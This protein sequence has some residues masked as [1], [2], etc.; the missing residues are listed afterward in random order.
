LAVQ[1]N[2]FHFPLLVHPFRDVFLDVQNK[3]VTVPRVGLDAVE[4]TVHG[5]FLPLNDLVKNTPETH[6]QAGQAILCIVFFGNQA[7][8]PDVF[9][10]DVFLYGTDVSKSYHPAIYRTVFK[11]WKSYQISI[12]PN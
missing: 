2:G 6:Q 10:R 12:F 11:K 1:E 8:G 4:T 7:D 9:R 5:F 3:K